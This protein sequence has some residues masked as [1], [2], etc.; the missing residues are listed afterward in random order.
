[1]LTET[2]L[3]LPELARFHNQDG[4]GPLAPE[5]TELAPGLFL[6]AD[7]NLGLS[8]SWRSPPGRLLELEARAASRGEWIALHLALP[9]SGLQDL[10]YLGYACRAAGP[11][12]WMIRPCLRSGLE[13]GGFTDT[14][15]GKHI[16]TTER[17]A[18]HLDA[19]YLD[20]CPELPLAAPWRELVMFL[21][22]EDFRIYLH[23]LYIF[24]L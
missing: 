24:A 10:T 3:P 7:P 22:C 9:L 18:S 20:S 5:T 13:D 1:M 11:K 21:P 17:P 16:L 15:F 14:F 19:L 23:H 2:P 6:N 8:G 4:A 12:P